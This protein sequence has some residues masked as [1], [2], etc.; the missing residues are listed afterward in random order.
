VT[1]LRHVNIADAVTEV[2]ASVNSSKE[3]LTKD[4]DVKLGQTDKTQFTKIT[5]GTNDASI[6]VTGA[7]LTSNF[8]LEVAKGNVP[9]HSHIN[10]FGHNQT[11]VAGDDVWGGGGVYVYYPTIA[12]PVDLVSTSTADDV[13]GTGAL[14]VEVE[15]LGEN[16]EEQSETV[17]LD[18]TGV[19]QLSLNYVRLFRA[20]VTEA[21]TGNVNA[22]TITV[23]ARATGSGVTA[24]E[25]GIH[26]G[27]EDGQTLHAIYTI[28]GG[29]TGYF[30]KGYVGL[31]NSTFQGEDGTF[32]WLMR[33]NNGVNGAWLVQGEVGLVN[34]GNSYWQYEY[35]IP[36]GPLPERTDIRIQLHSATD[37]MDTVGGFDMLLVGDGF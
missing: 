29:K 5:D 14:Q 9:G 27:A 22:G 33:I 36:A 2:T 8:L 11:A 23:Y 35:G 37:T 10:K 16:W 28:P 12:V 13:G 24:G 4:T 7:L 17:I 20:F 30:I 32:R 1:K 6:N 3:L 18:G 31:K 25:V 19:V 15:G 34:I 21:G 26:L